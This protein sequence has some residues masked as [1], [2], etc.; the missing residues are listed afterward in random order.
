MITQEQLFAILEGTQRTLLI[1]GVA[2][3]FG[4]LLGV[5]IALMKISRSK[6]LNGLSWFYV[7]V[8]RGTPMLMQLF[9]FYYAMPLFTADV[10][11]VTLRI[12]ALTAAFIAFSLNSAA[13]LSEIFR[14]AIQS[15]D[16]GQMEAAKALGMSYYQAMFRIII[17]QSYRRLIPPLGNELITLVKDTSLVASISLFDLLRTVQVMNNSSG[18]WIY[19]LY[20]GALYLLFT[21][22]IQ[23]AF[24]KL[25]KKYSVYE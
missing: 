15:I 14:G 11:G 17:P 4:I 9:V 22:I 23:V 16:K 3:V 10:L 24:D 5:I 21:S 25:E 19:F 12:P 18:E 7:W 8:F 6:V 13:Y 2:I 20:A 1:A